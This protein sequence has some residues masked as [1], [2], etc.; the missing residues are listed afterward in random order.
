MKNDVAVILG[1]LDELRT[2]AQA[3]GKENEKFIE[4]L[5]RVAE[6]MRLARQWT[7][8]PNCGS[9]RGESNSAT[10]STQRAFHVKGVVPCAR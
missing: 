8:R 2:K 9:G 6:R 3:F 1:R 4:H 10:E 5:T 7:E